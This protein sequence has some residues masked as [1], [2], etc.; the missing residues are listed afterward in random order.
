MLE[1]GERFVANLPD[2]LLGEAELVADLFEGHGIL[3]VQTE[4]KL[5]DLGL[6]G[7]ERFECGTD[8]VDHSLVHDDVF[9]RNRVFVFYD[10]EEGR[11]RTV[12]QRGGE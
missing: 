9:G 4:V 5:Q 2:S 6:S 10:F 11:I 8:L 12:L 1:C 7:R 3:G